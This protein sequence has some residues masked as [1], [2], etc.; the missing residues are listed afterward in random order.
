MSPSGRLPAIFLPTRWNVVE[1]GFHGADDPSPLV[2]HRKMKRGLAL[3]GAVDRERG[4]AAAAQ[5]WSSSL[6]ASSPG[7]LIAT[8]GRAPPRGLRNHPGIST[9]S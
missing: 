5:A 4:H 6:Q 8:D 7:D 9:P 3:A 1:K 2:G